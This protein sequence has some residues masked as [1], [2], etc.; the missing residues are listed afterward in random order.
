MTTIGRDRASLLDLGRSWSTSLQIWPRSPEVAPICPKIGRSR[1]KLDQHNQQL[2]GIANPP[3]TGRILAAEF[4]VA[5]IKACASG[6]HMEFRSRKK[7]SRRRRGMQMQ[8]RS[9]KKSPTRLRHGIWANTGRDWSNSG[10]SASIRSK[11]AQICWMQA[12]VCPIRPPYD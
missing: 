7:N 12:K 3:S 5:P 1:Y 6:S 11:S 10:R 8:I 9:Y 2:A 4:E